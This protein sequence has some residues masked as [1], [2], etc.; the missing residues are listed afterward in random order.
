[1]SAQSTSHDPKTDH[2]SLVIIAVIGLGSLIAIAGANGAFEP[3]SAAPTKLYSVDGC[4]LYRFEDNSETGYFA[5]CSNGKASTSVKGK[6]VTTEMV[7]K[8]ELAPKTQTEK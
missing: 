7:P 5:R 1:M 4:D 6:H 3:T 2:R 8:S